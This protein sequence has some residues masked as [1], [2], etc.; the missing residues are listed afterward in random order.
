MPS[1]STV[2]IVQP[3]HMCLHINDARECRLLNQVA[4]SV[5][6]CSDCV[7]RGIWYTGA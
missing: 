6:C 1:E 7:S 2:T 5:F 4:L 3:G